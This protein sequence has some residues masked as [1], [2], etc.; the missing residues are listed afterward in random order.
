MTRSSSTKNKQANILFVVGQLYLI[1]NYPT[2]FMKTRKGERQRKANKFTDIL[3][4]TLYISNLILFV[5]SNWRWKIG[6]HTLRSHVLSYWLIWEHC[7]NQNEFDACRY[8]LYV[9]FDNL[10]R[11]IWC[12]YVVPFNIRLQYRI[13]MNSTLFR[14]S[15]LFFFS[16]CIWNF[17]NCITVVTINI[18]NSGKKKCDLVQA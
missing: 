5:G 11:C 9:Y 6:A 18:T 15:F 7:G 14:S 10:L 17:V 2:E 13:S 8:T 4:R 12:F 16:D 1:I 3:T